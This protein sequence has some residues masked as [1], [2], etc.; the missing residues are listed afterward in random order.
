[1]YLKTVLLLLTNSS[2]LHAKQGLALYS[3]VP[4]LFFWMYITTFKLGQN[5]LVSTVTQKNVW[6]TLK[7]YKDVL[8]IDIWDEFNVDLSVTFQTR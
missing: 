1:M 4:I 2:S 8:Y 7:L 5:Q 3:L 6:I